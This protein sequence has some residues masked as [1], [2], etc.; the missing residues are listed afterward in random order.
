[1]KHLTQK[2]RG[3]F[4]RPS[5]QNFLWSKIFHSLY[6][7]HASNVPTGSHCVGTLG[8][9]VSVWF[10]ALLVASQQRLCT[11]IPLQLGWEQ[12][13]KRIFSLLAVHTEEMSS[14]LLSLVV[15]LAERDVNAKILYRL[16]HSCFGDA[17]VLVQ[18]WCNFISIKSPTPNFAKIETLI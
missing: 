2:S 4:K 17:V 6:T 13:M 3:G 12:G 5:L 10:W 16:I 14:Y 11:S 7:S 15:V 8:Q 18:T 9:H 1:M